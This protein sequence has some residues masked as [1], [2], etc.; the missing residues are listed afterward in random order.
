MAAQLLKTNP[1]LRHEQVKWKGMMHSEIQLELVQQQSAMH[2]S[3]IAVHAVSSDDRC[4]VVSSVFKIHHA[5][6]P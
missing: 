2:P 3:I 5:N 1:P 4:G 6:S